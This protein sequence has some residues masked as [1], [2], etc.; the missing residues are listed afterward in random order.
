MPGLGVFASVLRSV[1]RDLDSCYSATAIV[2]SLVSLVPSR[3]LRSG[4]KAR[5]RICQQSTIDYHVCIFEG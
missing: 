2:A 5:A 1:R 3:G 4:G